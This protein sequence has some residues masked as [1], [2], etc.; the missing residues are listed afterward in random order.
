MYERQ[1][2]KINKLNIR[3]NSKC[4]KYDYEIGDKALLKHDVNNDI[5]HTI[6]YVNEGPYHIM[7]VY[8]NGTIRI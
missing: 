7:K 4:F 8:S 6:D 3:E 2:H 5:I 1:Q